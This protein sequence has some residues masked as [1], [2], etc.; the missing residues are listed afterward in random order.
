MRRLFFYINTTSLIFSLMFCSAGFASYYPALL[1]SSVP[2]IT[3]APLTKQQSNISALE[4]IYSSATPFYPGERNQLLRLH[5]TWMSSSP[6]GNINTG[7]FG[8]AGRYQVSAMEDVRGWHSFYGSG[9]LFRGNVQLPAGLFRLGI[10]SALGGALELGNFSKLRKQLRQDKQADCYQS[11]W[12]PL[13][14]VSALAAVQPTEV[15]SLS[16][17]F[18]ASYPGIYA[19]SIVFNT[20]GVSLWV[21][22]FPAKSAKLALKNMDY[23]TIGLTVK[24]F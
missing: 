22:A 3:T 17:Q 18:S 24:Q 14:G 1:G 4:F 13:L 10:G 20:P 16:F 8:Y 7:I 5:R 11:R 2:P 19:A 23:Y 21:S 6:L 12:L 15:L 9:I